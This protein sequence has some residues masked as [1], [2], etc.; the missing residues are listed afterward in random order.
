M[1]EIDTPP[2]PALYTENLL[3]AMGPVAISPDALTL[4][5]VHNAGEGGILSS[6]AL[7]NSNAE[8]SG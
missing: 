1:S 5:T 7:S 2:S 3:I 8:A 4:S 6:M